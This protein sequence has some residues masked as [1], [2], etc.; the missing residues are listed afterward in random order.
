MIL[1]IDTY[2]SE[3]ALAPNRILD[4]FLKEVQENSYVY[5]KQS[6]LDILKYSIASYVPIKW[7]KVVIRLD[8]DLKNEIRQLKGYIE[9]CF[10]DATIA[11]TRSDTGSKYAEVL[12]TMLKD[13]PW[14]FF[15]PNNDHPFIYNKPEIIDFLQKSAE[16]AEKKFRLPVSILYSH[17]TESINS[18][19]PLGYL[20]GYTGDFCKIIDEDE[21][22]Y[23]VKYDH[24]SLL[25]LQIFRA[26]HLYEMMRAAGNNRVIRPECL[27]QYVDYQTES[28]QIVPKV[29]CCR[30]YDAYMHT[31]FVVSD[32]ITASR[33]PPLFIPDHFFE[34][35][36][37]IKYGFD[38]YYQ[39]FVN[40]NPLKNSYSFNSKNG[41]DLAVLA[42]EI[43]SFW[44]GRIES[45][46]VNPEIDKLKIKESCLSMEIKNPWRDKSDSYMKVIILYRKFYFLF[47]MPMVGDSY[48]SF[49]G[50]LS[51]LK[52]KCYSN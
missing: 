22:S 30:H 4:N 2:I 42:D 36:I 1:Y 26:E 50:Y 3:T 38:E 51:T 5:R 9:E 13:N 18:I 7:S 40:I 12:A 19:S 15:S 11:F 25:S 17:F 28:V 20:Y 27:G 41:T 43:P 39:D 29:E 47:L 32:Y 45:F 8:G 16:K 6:K 14:V 33:V 34:N 35:K 52:M 10:P 49:R 23:T 46:E 21:F 44:N 37:K 31:S 24:A 48:R